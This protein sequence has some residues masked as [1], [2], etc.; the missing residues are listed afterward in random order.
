MRTID[1]QLRIVTLDGS[2][3]QTIPLGA[4]RTKEWS[5]EYVSGISLSEDGTRVAY[6]V[7]SIIQ[8]EPDFHEA[9]IAD[10]ATGI[11]RRFQPGEEI[12]PIVRAPE[13]EKIAYIHFSTSDFLGELVFADPAGECLFKPQLPSEIRSISWSPDG[14]MIAFDGIYVLDLASARQDTQQGEGC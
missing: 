5:S 1:R 3:H 10:I 12:G 8:D 4:M 13:G 14:S 6:S 9:F 7:F 2:I 11:V